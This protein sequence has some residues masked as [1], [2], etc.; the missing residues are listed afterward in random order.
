MDLDLER[1]NA[2]FANQP[3]KL[4]AWALSLGKPAICTTNFRPFEAVILHM[5]TQAQ[6][7]LPIVWMDSGYNTE[8]TYRFA[9]EVARKLDLN[10]ITYLPRRSRAH[11]EALEGPAPGLDDP[12]HAAFTEEVKLEPFARALRETAPGVWFTALRASDTA[13]RAQMEPVSINPDGLIKVAPL[14]P[15]TSKDL[16]QYLTAHDL[17]NNFDYFDPT[18]G[19]ENREC[20]LHL[21]H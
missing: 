4:I 15:W 7:D 14:L 18:K 13:V 11:R 12:R 8:A 17:P 20:G 3:E 16:Y 6:P 10:L 21:S 5:V 9:D 19:E 2:E 1:I